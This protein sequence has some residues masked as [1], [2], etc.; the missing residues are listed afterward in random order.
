[1]A[2]RIITAVAAALALAMLVALWV[3]HNTLRGNFG[4]DPNAV[5]FLVPDGS[6]TQQRKQAADFCSNVDV[7]RIADALDSDAT[8]AAVSS[9]YAESVEPSGSPRHRVIRAGC[10]AG[11]AR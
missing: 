2:W 8:P 11:L 3:Q 10:L 5:V 4:P 7:Q 6:L 1:M 9:A